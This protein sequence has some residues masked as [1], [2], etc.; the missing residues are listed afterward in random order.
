L[1]TGGQFD[2]EKG[3]QFNAENGGQFGAKRGGLLQRNFQLGFTVMY[4]CAV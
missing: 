1:K 4:S 3:G 2:A